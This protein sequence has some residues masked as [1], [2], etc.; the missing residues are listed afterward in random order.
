MINAEQRRDDFLQ[1][2]IKM[3]A[4]DAESGRPYI[5]T[6]RGRYLLLAGVLQAIVETEWLSAAERVAKMQ[7]VL[8]GFEIAQES[9]RDSATGRRDE[10]CPTN[11]LTGS[12]NI[13]ST[14][15]SGTGT[16]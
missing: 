14:T 6:I 7:V 3:E 8:Q 13:S 5:A 15:T 4:E 10:R 16:A 9:I 12:A 2:F 11:S 1:G